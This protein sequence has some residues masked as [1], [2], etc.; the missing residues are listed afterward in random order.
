MIVLSNSNA[1][2]LLPGQS[3]TFNVV[4]LHTGCGECYRPNSGVVNLAGKG[5][6]YEVSFSG[7][8]GTET[9][10]DEAQLAIALDNSPLLETTMIS[11]M[12]AVGD[13]NNVSRGT[14]V[15]TCCCNSANAITVINTGSTTVNIDENPLLKIKRN[16]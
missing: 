13:L 16:A 3:A 8:I 9:A 10:G 6:I 15:R 14:Y 1:Q 7:N 2:T 11:T 5:S 12:A 4:V